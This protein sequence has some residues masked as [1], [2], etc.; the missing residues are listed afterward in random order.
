M[1]NKSD[2]WNKLNI[3]PKTKHLQKEFYLFRSKDVAKMTKYYIVT[4]GGNLAL[5]IYQYS[6]D[7]SNAAFLQMIPFLIVFA[8]R[9]LVFM[10]RDRFSNQL[11]YFFLVIAMFQVVQCLIYT[12]GSS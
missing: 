11:G 8:L 2:C 6:D 1:L 7:P 3:Q 12:P 10:L 5:A 4:S 9:I